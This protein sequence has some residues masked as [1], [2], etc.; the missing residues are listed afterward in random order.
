MPE[1]M[2][3]NA[4]HL[5]KADFAALVKF[6]VSP[7]LEQPD[8]LRVDC[9][10]SPNRQRVWV[11]LAFDSS[12]KGRVFGRGGRN[13][14]AIR[15]VLTAAARVSGYTTHLEIYGSPAGSRDWEGGEQPSTP[16]KRPPARR[17]SDGRDLPR[18]RSRT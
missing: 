14:Q 18:Q 12:D 9:E 7:F 3:E 13:I 17:N 5:E 10:V 2:A 16:E 8:K 4:S 11:R 1:A 15:T 6:L